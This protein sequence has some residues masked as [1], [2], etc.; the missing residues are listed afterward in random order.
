MCFPPEASPVDR[1][2]QGCAHEQQRR[3]PVRQQS[4]EHA[5]PTSEGKQ[6]HHEDAGPDQALGE[7]LTIARR[8]EMGQYRTVDPHSRESIAPATSPR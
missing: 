6:D 1:D 3:A 7:D 2:R 4:A 5:E 8:L